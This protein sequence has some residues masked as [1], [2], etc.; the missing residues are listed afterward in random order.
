MNPAVVAAEIAANCLNMF[1][2]T[3]LTSVTAVTRKLFPER[4][5]HGCEMSGEEVIGIKIDTRHPV[6]L[7]SIANSRSHCLMKKKSLSDM[8]PRKRLK[9]GIDRILSCRRFYM[10]CIFGFEV[11]YSIFLNFGIKG[12]DNNWSYLDWTENDVDLLYLCGFEQNVLYG[13]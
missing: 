6:D 11:W 3:W 2:S 4:G 13:S 12:L 8:S 1:H 7:Y 9:A 5:Q 10:H